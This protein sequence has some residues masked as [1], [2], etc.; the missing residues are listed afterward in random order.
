MDE[1]V[2]VD[3]D[4]EWP[5]RFAEIA[6]RVQTAFRDGPLITV[7]HIGSTAVPGLAAKPIIDIDIVILSSS[8][9]PN[10]IARLAVIGYVHEG[11]KGVEGR[12]AFHWPPRTTRHHLYLCLSDN[13]EYH[14]HIAF[15][16]YLRNH[17]ITAGQ[18]QALKRNLALSFRDD[19]LAYN[20]GKTDFVEQVL[21]KA[22]SEDNDG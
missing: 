11:N 19:R 9:I 6:G 20:E 3:Y 18:Y 14:R 13:A 2:V 21:E 12:E 22:R 5:T 4:P 1:I 15:R 16:D 17:A 7:E 8:D 10:S